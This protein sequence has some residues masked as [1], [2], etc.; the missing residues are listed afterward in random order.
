MAYLIDVDFNPKDPALMHI[1]INSCFATIE[2]QANPLLRGKPIAVGAYTTLNGCILAASR[3]AK[4]F[5][6]KTGMRVKEGKLLCPRLI[7]LPPDPWK[8]RNIHLKLRELFKDYTEDFTPKSID[9]FVL[10]LEGYP[11]F[12]RGMVNVAREIKNRIRDEIGDWIT[13]SIG[14]GSNRFL[15]KTGAGL[16]KP[17]GLDA[18]T[19]DNYLEIYKKLKLT[20]LC[21]IASHNETRL[22]GVGI[23]TVLDLYKADMYQLRAAF[24]SVASLYW[25][26]RL[27]G[28]EID[29]MPTSR[30]SYGNSYV[31]PKAFD[32]E[33]ELIPI[34]Q[35][36]VEKMSGRLRKA[37]YKARGVHLSIAYRDKNFWHQGVGVQR[38]LFE[39]REIFREIYKLFKKSPFDGGP[40]GQFAV[41]C[42][43]LVKN[44]HTQLEIFEDVGKKESLARAVDDI[45][46]KWGDFMIAPLR[47]IPS[48][49][50]VPDRIAF[51]G[52][53]ELE[54]FTFAKN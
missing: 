4:K 31:L 32:T 30:K 15:A 12:S 22:R 34:L 8:Y 13:V 9:E 19:K 1:D 42:F 54:E 39:S 52:I 49:Q 48:K 16:T 10:D 11:A 45:N 50:Y 28:W 51:G 17:D 25:Y 21:G 33:K 37:G 53:K 5:G 14:I 23:H 47:M 35:K 43:N 18:I 6:V 38:D 7:V 41:S 27:R 46:H 36:L 20:D 29:S 44:D 26:L 3:E 24:H 40:V 2:Q